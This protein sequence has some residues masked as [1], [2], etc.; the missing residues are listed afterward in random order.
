M[1]EKEETASLLHWRRLEWK[2][3]SARVAFLVV[4]SIFLSC[5]M[6]SKGL[7][8]GEGQKHNGCGSSL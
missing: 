3:E 2:Q 1:A 4:P 6:W 5:G 8:S 7:K